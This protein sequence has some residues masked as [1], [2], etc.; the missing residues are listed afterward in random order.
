MIQRSKSWWRL[1]NARDQ[2]KIITMAGCLN[3]LFKPS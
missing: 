3:R 1:R 2:I